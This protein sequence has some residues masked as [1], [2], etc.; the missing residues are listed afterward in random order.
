MVGGY[1]GKYYM[2]QKW[3]KG[4]F[5]K[6]VRSLFQD[7]AYRQIGKHGAAPR[8]VGKRVGGR[9]VQMRLESL[10]ILKQVVAC[11]HGF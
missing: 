8:M 6:K 3:A 2:R 7:L 5:L 11:S 4:Y 9:A 10:G 1:Y